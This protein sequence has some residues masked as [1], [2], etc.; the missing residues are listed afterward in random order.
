[1]RRTLQ[2]M[3]EDGRVIR[4]YGGATLAHGRVV[5]ALGE[6]D[7]EARPSDVSGRPPADW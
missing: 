1:M 6:T 5:A 2:R 4:T 3:A 7:P